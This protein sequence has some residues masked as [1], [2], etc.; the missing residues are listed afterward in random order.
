MFCSRLSYLETTRTGKYYCSKAYQRWK[1]ISRT[2]PRFLLSLGNPTSRVVCLLRNYCR[3]Q[4]CWWE[5]RR[6]A[7]QRGTRSFIILVV[8]FTRN[9]IPGWCLWNTA[10]FKL[11]SRGNYQREINNWSLNIWIP[12]DE[13]PLSTH[14]LNN[15][16]QGQQQKSSSIIIIGNLT[17]Y[18]VLITSLRLVPFNL[19]W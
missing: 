1:I 18:V 11:L 17:M 7:T 10:R 19:C 3:H 6:E 15:Q 5:T 2:K 12:C 4:A 16:N 8:A 9:E 13:N 14:Y